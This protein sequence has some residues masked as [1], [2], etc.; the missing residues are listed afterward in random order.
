[1]LFLKEYFI[2][3]RNLISNYA[4]NSATPRICFRLTREREPFLR[5]QRP[6]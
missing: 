2:F 6:N 5:V 3:Y 4:Q 1:M